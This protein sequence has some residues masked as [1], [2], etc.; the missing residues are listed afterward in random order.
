MSM[1][2]FDPD[3]PVASVGIG[4]PKTICERCT[5]GGPSYFAAAT[6]A[7]TASANPLGSGTPS[8]GTSSFN[9]RLSTFKSFLVAGRKPRYPRIVR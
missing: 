1:T 3:L 4:Q 8:A 9:H 6:S 7:C 2:V 5:S